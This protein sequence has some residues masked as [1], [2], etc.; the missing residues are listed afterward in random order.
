M[1]SHI[2]K[3]WAVCLNRPADAPPTA[4]IKKPNETGVFYLSPVFVILATN[5]GAFAKTS[6]DSGSAPEAAPK[7]RRREDFEQKT[8]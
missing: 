7:A 2:A 6:D 1:F 4:T 5:L 8:G 3:R